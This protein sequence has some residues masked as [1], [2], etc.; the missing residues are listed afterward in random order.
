MKKILW[1]F[2]SFVALLTIPLW[3]LVLHLGPW[4][5]K[6]YVQSGLL[7]SFVMLILVFK[8]NATIKR[9]DLNLMRVFSAAICI[10]LI[11]VLLV[12]G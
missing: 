6:A 9:G 8:G 4:G 3:D 7:I 5:Y 11:V 2:V 12:A 10:I 1:W